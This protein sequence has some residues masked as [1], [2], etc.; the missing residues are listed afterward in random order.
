MSVPIITCSDGLER[1]SSG[2]LGHHAGGGLGL[3]P[4]A[5][6]LVLGDNAAECDAFSTTVICFAVT[7][8]FQGSHKSHSLDYLT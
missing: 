2:K 7:I 3:K 5:G 1:E 8:A 6:A 4:F